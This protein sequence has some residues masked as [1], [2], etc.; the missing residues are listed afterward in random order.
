MDLSPNR[1]AALDYRRKA[2]VLRS[3]I[4][5]IADQETRERIERLA[6]RWDAKATV[7]ESEIAP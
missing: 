4:W 2:A 5:G 3:S 6:E 1:V 7:A